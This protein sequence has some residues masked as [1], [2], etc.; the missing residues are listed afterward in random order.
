MFAEIFALLF[1]ASHWLGDTGFLV[2][3]AEHLWYSV[4]AVGIAAVI[5]FPLGI[6][7]GH[8]GR[9]AV[10][11]VGLANVVRA[12]PSL[13]LMTL[14]VLLIGLGLLPPVLALVALAVPPLLAGVYSGIE[15]VDRH[16]V[17][18]ARGMGMTELQ[19]VFK[20]EL[21]IALPLIVAGLRNAML[22]VISTATIAAYV[23][24]GGIGRYIFDGLAV[25]DYARM[26]VGAILVTG[27]ALAVD[28]IL[29]WVGTRVIPGKPALSRH[30][31]PAA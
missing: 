31:A 4:L 8:T 21:P 17:D 28:G 29:A 12:I 7:V 19:I 5:A 1:D 20:C 15:N 27:L 14:L 18:A 25:Y 3:I 13:G 9:G 30:R 23:N 26:V 11:A 10:I 16:T 2:R 22:Q 6:F 24:L